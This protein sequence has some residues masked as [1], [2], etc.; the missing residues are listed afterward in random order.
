MKVAEVKSCF[1]K[2][3]ESSVKHYVKTNLRDAKEG[4]DQE[5]EQDKPFKE[6]CSREVSE[7]VTYLRRGVLIFECMGILPSFF[8][9]PVQL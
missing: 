5:A 4:Q 6:M 3:S 8:C 7:R 1:L 9:I 2:K